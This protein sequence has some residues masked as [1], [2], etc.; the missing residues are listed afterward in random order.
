VTLATLEVASIGGNACSQQIIK[1][2]K[3]KLNIRRVSVSQ[4]AIYMLGLPVTWIDS[5]QIIISDI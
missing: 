4:N 1:D 3:D 5:V 2:M